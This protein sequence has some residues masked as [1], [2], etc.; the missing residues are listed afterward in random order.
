MI[1]QLQDLF[2]EIDSFDGPP[3]D[4][5]EIDRIL[6]DRSRDR[7][8]SWSGVRAYLHGSHA[9]AEL[10]AGILEIRVQERFI[11]TNPQEGHARVR[12]P[13]Q[14]PTQAESRLT[15]QGAVGHDQEI[16]SRMREGMQAA[17]AHP[18]FI[19]HGEWKCGG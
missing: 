15:A 7:G 8:R 17:N 16:E 18:G 14:I 9:I 6:S 2:R 10:L 11:L 3:P 12:H 1:T 19:V 4:N 5:N 13:R